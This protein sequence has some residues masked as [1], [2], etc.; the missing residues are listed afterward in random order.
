MESVSLTCDHCLKQQITFVKQCGVLDPI[1]V[2]NPGNQPVTGFLRSMKGINEV[3]LDEIM[4]GCEEEK[5]SDGQYLAQSYILKAYMNSVVIQSPSYLQTDWQQ[6]MQHMN[7]IISAAKYT[8]NL[9]HQAILCRANLYNSVGLFQVAD[10]DLNSLEKQYTNNGLFHVIKSGALFQFALSNRN[11]LEPLVKCSRLLPNIYELQFQTIRAQTNY[12]VD[13][14]AST[15]HML[16]SLEHLTKRFPAELAPRILLIALYIELDIRKAT[17]ILKQARK[18][19]PN[20]LDEL[21]SMDGLLNSNNPSCVKYFKRA[22]RANKE[23]LNSFQG[24]LDYFSLSTYEY[25]KAIEV[26]TAALLN[27][28][29]EDDFK[30]MFEHRQLLLKKII[31]QNFWEKL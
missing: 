19:F 6:D 8:E 14:I 16:A 17:N 12:I 26:S 7:E 28:L 22:L 2:P 21:S 4:A 27:F 13:P 10:C 29:R 18:D 1:S 20:R 30:S 25:A 15:A 31:R 23:D 9:K 11:F 5:S 3:N 24:L